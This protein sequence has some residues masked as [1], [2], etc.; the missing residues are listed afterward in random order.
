MRPS[1]H[2]YDR[3]VHVAGANERR[4]MP[5]CRFMKKPASSGPFHELST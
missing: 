4:P 5:R 1:M 2:Q 3:A